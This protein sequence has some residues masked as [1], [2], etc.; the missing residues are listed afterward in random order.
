MEAGLSTPSSIPHL[1]LSSLF[2]DVMVGAVC[3]GVGGL[4][5]RGFLCDTYQFASSHFGSRKGL[6]VTDLPDCLA[7]FPSEGISEAA[8]VWLILR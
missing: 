8:S 7:S 4:C 2:L 6:L 5:L 1:L 3:A